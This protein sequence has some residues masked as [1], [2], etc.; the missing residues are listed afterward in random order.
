MAGWRAS[1][2]SACES[3]GGPP[4]DTRVPDGRWAAYLP[5]GRP[6]RVLSP[7]LARGE[8]GFGN[9]ARAYAVRLRRFACFII[10][11]FFLF[12]QWAGSHTTRPPRTSFR[13][14]CWPGRILCLREARQ[15]SASTS[16]PTGRENCVLSRTEDCLL[17]VAL[18]PAPPLI[19]RARVVVGDSVTARN[20]RRGATLQVAFTPRRDWRP[21]HCRRRHHRHDVCCR[22]YG[23]RIGPRRTHKE[24]RGSVSD[25][26]LTCCYG[27][28]QE[29]CA[30]G[31]GPSSIPVRHRFKEKTCVCVCARARSKSV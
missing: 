25:I 21:P 31:D 30:C 27:G 11:L 9:C 24:G 19:T 3:Q 12:F 20:A 2:R 17:Q 22:R 6:F 13:P 7:S 1:Q 28:R 8:S 4:R 15:H 26:T 16:A 29:A 5:G 14:S 10:L 18:G 23:E